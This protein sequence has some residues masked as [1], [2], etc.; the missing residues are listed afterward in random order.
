[1][2]AIDEGDDDDKFNP[3]KQQPPPSTEGEAAGEAAGGGVGGSNGG[4]RVAVK[5]LFD[6]GGVEEGDLPFLEGETF[7]VIRGIEPPYSTVE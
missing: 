1:V 3:Q 6:F 2:V 4:G 7:E 5:A